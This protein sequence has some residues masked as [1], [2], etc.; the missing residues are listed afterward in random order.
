MPK[1]NKIY[2]IRKLGCFHFGFCFI[3]NYPSS[4]KRVLKNAWQFSHI[5]TEEA[6]NLFMN[7]DCILQN[8]HLLKHFLEA[9]QNSKYKINY[10]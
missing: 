5:V 8:P 4:Q 7:F 6:D 2:G 3:C 10:N 1:K 9:V